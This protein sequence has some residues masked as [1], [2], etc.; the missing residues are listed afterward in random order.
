M[1]LPGREA[2]SAKFEDRGGWWFRRVA[3]RLVQ[4]G[5][6]GC[7]GLRATTLDL[8]SRRRAMRSTRWPAPTRSW[9]R[10]AVHLAAAG[11]LMSIV[12]SC[13][14]ALDAN[15]TWRDFMAASSADRDEAV[16]QVALA[17][18]APESVTPLGRPNIDYLC[19]G[20]PN[21]TLGWAVKITG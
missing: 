21:Q 3:V 8:Y 12:A 5:E 10:R 9:L 17:L 6:Q 2:N 13:G 19:A 20:S 14:G 16:T 15:S 7:N 11:L 18:H 1:R 4:F